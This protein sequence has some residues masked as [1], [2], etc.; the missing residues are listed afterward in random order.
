MMNPADPRTPP[1]E[2]IARAIHAEYVA[3]FLPDPARTPAFP[4]WDDLPEEFR[5]ANRD[6]ARNIVEKLRVLGLGI[7]PV[8]PG[9]TSERIAFTREQL[10]QLS[11]MEHDR[12]MA[13]KARNGW[14]RGPVRDNDRKVHPDL[15]PWEALDETAKDKDRNAV[16]MIPKILEE[17]GYTIRPLV[18][19]PPR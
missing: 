13:E 10:E 1:I 2:S 3:R 7:A 8:F 19:S 16:R 9:A 11:R 18:P 17:A 4:P 12:W 15:I 14:V 5:E 6:Q